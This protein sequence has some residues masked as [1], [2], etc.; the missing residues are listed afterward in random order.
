MKI[1]LRKNCSKTEFFLGCIFHIWTEYG[2]LAQSKYGKI[3]T[4]E[5]PYFGHFSRS[6]AVDHL[7]KKPIRFLEHVCVRTCKIL[8][9]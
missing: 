9:C 3:R 6:A 5:T 8:G 1:A 4:R 7:N 2:D